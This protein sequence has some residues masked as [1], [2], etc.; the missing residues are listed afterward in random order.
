MT[1]WTVAQQA[2]L[3]MGFSRQEYWSGL[4]FPSPGD[5]PNT[6]IQ[7]QSPADSLSSEPPGKPHVYIYPLPLRPPPSPLFHPSGSSQS[8]ELSSLSY[9]ASSSQLSIFAQSSVYMSVL[10]FVSSSHPLLLLLH[11]QVHSLHLHLYCCPVD[12]FISTIFLDSTYTC[13]YLIFR[14]LFLT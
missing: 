4:P 13:W 6:G 14:F 8:T 5:L 1:P 10:L 2:P 12:R 9:A 11:P 3:S 7:P